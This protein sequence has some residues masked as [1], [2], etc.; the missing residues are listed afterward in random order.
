MNMSQY[1]PPKSIG[2]ADKY[3][4][5][6]FGSHYFFGFTHPGP[7]WWLLFRILRVLPFTF[8]K[9]RITCKRF[10]WLAQKKS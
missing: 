8:Q 2:K 10:S 3:Y 7:L 5:Y 1:Q 9:K 4:P 6:L